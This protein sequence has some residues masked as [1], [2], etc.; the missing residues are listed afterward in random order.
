MRRSLT[1]DSL[2]SVATCVTSLYLVTSQ[3]KLPSN[4][5]TRETGSVARRRAYSAGGSM[6]EA[7]WNGNLGGST[8]IVVVIA[9]KF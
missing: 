8:D 6:P 2:S 1:L 9:V 7:R 4:N 5:V 3:A